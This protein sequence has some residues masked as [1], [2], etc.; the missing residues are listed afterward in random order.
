MAI[1]FFLQVLVLLVLLANITAST[2][3]RESKE[4]TVQV[5]E[6]ALDESAC[7][8]SSQGQACRTLEYV[9]TK[10][11]ADILQTL[12][13]SKLIINVTYNQTIRN[14]FQAS[15][16]PSECIKEIIIVGSNN[17]FINF[18][19]TSIIIQIT[20]EKRARETNEVS[21][22]YC[23]SWVG[24]GFALVADPSNELNDIDVFLPIIGMHVYYYLKIFN[25]EFVSVSLTSEFPRG[26]AINSND[27]GNGFCPILSFQLV[28]ST[29]IANNTF[30]NCQHYSVFENAV[31]E[32]ML[33]FIA[34]NCSIE[35]SNNLFSNVTDS[36]YYRPVISIIGH[37]AGIIIQGNQFIG[38]TM[39]FILI[40]T[41]VLQNSLVGNPCT[42]CSVLE[43]KY[44]YNHF[45]PTAREPILVK[46]VVDIV[47]STCPMKTLLHQN[48]F[49]NNT[50]T[51]LLHTEVKSKY[52]QQVT[53]TSL[54]VL[55]N[56]G[57]SPLVTLKHEGI[58]SVILGSLT[59]ERNIGLYKKDSES[60]ERTI[61]YVKNANQSI[62]RDSTFQNNLGTPLV[63]EN[64]QFHNDLCAIRNLSFKANTGVYGGA[65]SLYNV[66]FNSSCE[67]K[68]LFEKN[69]AV[70][71]GALYLKDSPSLCVCPGKCLTTLEFL[72]N[73]ATAAGNSVYFASSSQF[74]CQ[75][76]SMKDV[77]SAASSIVLH[78]GDLRIFPGQNII[79][80][81]SIT[82]QFDQ[83][84][85]CTTDVSLYCEGQLYT[86]FDQDIKLSGPDSV[87]L[88]QLPNTESSLI[89]TN[90][91]LQSYK[92]NDAL[93]TSLNLA[94]KNS[95]A[96][97]KIG[98]KIYGNCSQGFFYNSTLNVCKC[99]IKTKHKLYVCSTVL[100][101]ACVSHGYW[102]GRVSNEYVIARCKYSECKMNNAHCPSGI[103]SGSN[104]FLL[105][106]TQCS[107]RR[108]GVLCRTCAEHFVFSFLSIHCIPEENC[109]SS[110]AIAI[111]FFAILF[112]ILITISLIFVVRFKHSLGCG[113]LYGPMLFLAMVNHIPLDD[114]SEYSTL[115]S[116]VSI[117]SS[118]ALLNLELFGRIPWCFFVSIPK[119]YN[120]SLRVLGPLTVLLVLLGIT[121]LVRWYPKCSVFE[122]MRLQL[123]Q[124]FFRHWH[125][126]HWLASPLKA[127]CILMMLSFWSLADI[128]INILTPTVL[129]TQHYYSMYMVSIQPDII[130]FSHNEHLPLAIPALLV[131]LVVILPLVIILLSA[132]FLQRVINL[133]KIKP[134][135]DEFQSCYKDKYRWYSGVYFVVWIAIVGMQGLPDSLL[136]TQTLF[137]ILLC[138]QFLIKPYKSKLLNI[139][140]TLLLVDVN[141]LI[142]LFYNKVNN[143]LLSDKFLSFLIHALIIVPFVCAILSPV[144]LLLIKYGVHD[145]VKGFWNKRKRG[146]ELQ[147]PQ[148]AQREFELSHPEV[149][150]QEVR[151]PDVSFSTERE[152]LIAVV[153]YR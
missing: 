90:L 9:M 14:S 151:V 65:M 16:P 7:Y 44:Q 110:K 51:R 13:A 128:S 34:Q 98:L 81:I 146:Q 88:V 17:A 123:P 52:M 91:R 126:S 100:G 132:P 141:F 38:N 8:L 54:A 144:C 86:C 103:Q 53:V 112:Q 56:S 136:Y 135:L 48:S 36:L 76:F 75:N 1:Q 59:V 145:C 148:G 102:Y 57:T 105:N 72:D 134:F 129:E 122:K 22:G 11:L 71:G 131:L 95:N 67:S 113:F 19:N 139:T 20:Q 50:S 15:L 4:F 84:S 40:D 58:I 150:V 87:V 18:K 107:N 25:C 153:D 138:A 26:I 133:I 124:N 147:Q 10:N 83:P 41:F 125:A 32:Y 85:L 2:C 70:Y 118:V 89:D 47:N 46:V 106:G 23:W 115:S 78:S 101:A 97:I 104:Y 5:N 79:I 77:G 49:E 73:R 33:D 12:E 55:N 130:Y 116:A 94:C 62:I 82:D 29:V 63:F 68:I 24:L 28:N 31:P 96:S 109:T 143:P 140:D 43:N 80:N 21:N 66:T 45:P 127:M 37:S 119:L 35:I 39:S 64:E 3:H 108:G 137:F 114:Y 149:P 120:Y 142:A 92:H 74:E 152:P 121:A 42:W 61:V 60:L 30:E 99:A 117:I 69:Y 111:L 93:D 6:S 27:F